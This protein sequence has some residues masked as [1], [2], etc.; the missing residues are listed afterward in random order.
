PGP[1]QTNI[2]LVGLPDWELFLYELP[3]AVYWDFCR[4]MDTLSDLDWTRFAS[5]VLD[6]QTALRLAEKQAH[7]PDWVM[8]RWGSR[9]GRVRD[10]LHL[11]EGLELLRPRDLILNGQSSPPLRT[12]VTSSLRPD[13]SPFEGVSCPDWERRWFWSRPSML[14]HPGCCSSSKGNT[15]SLLKVHKLQSEIQPPAP[16]GQ[17]HTQPSIAEASCTSGLMCWSYEEVHAGTKEFSPTLQ[18]GEGGFGVVYKAT[19]RNTV[20]AVKVLKQDRLL[21]WKLLKESFRTE[22]EKLSKF[23]HPNIIDLLGF[24]EGPGT[25]CLIYNYMENKSLEHKLHNARQQGSCLSWSQRVGV[26]TGASTALQFLH[27]PPKGNAPLI[28][29]DV[30]SSNILLDQHMTAK[31]GDFGL[32][33]LAL[34]SSSPS[35]TTTLGCTTTIRG[36]LAYLPMEYVRKGELGTVVDVYSFGVVLL[37]VLT[38]RRALEKDKTSR[39]RYLKD[40]V[41]EI[42]ESPSGSSQ[43]TRHPAVAFPVETKPP[44]MPSPAVSA[45]G[46]S[47]PAGWMEMVALACMCL[48]KN[49]KRRPAMAEVGDRLPRLPAPCPPLRLAVLVKPTRAEAFPSMT[50]SPN[51]G[52]T[53]QPGDVSAPPPETST[54]ALQL[55]QTSQTSLLSPLKNSTAFHCSPVAPVTSLGQEGFCDQSPGGSPRQERQ[56]RSAASLSRCPL[57]ALSSPWS[58]GPQVVLMNPIKQ[59]FL[60]K[61]TLYEEGRIRTPEL[62]SSEDIYEGTSSGAPEESDELDY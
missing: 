9:N 18:V 3:S 20:C 44:G 58:P 25:V 16:P 47:E 13:S 53:G 24:S 17:P 39:E 14:A 37:E 36:T 31:L 52:L 55:P 5:L 26:V 60:Q 35:A 62:L 23:R 34:K 42:K 15:W 8:N 56:R 30:K 2:Q 38:G 10:L 28:H 33:S 59:H 22:M 1:G 4:V 32:A 46:A 43:K 49:R 19:L 21:D 50:S 41:D 29:G 12:P 40:L 7:A 61:K 57:C 54:A 51:S 11:L 6:D 45:G 27:C 48:D